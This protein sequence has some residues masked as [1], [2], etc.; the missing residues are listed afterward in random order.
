MEKIAVIANSRAG[1]GLE[2]TDANRLRQAVE[3]IGYVREIGYSNLSSGVDAAYKQFVEEA[4][5]KGVEIIAVNGGDGTIHR[6]VT[7]LIMTYGEKRLPCIAPLRGGTANALADDVGIRGKPEEILEKLAKLYKKNAL[8]FVTRTTLKLTRNDN[9]NTF[10]FDCDSG[11]GADEPEYGFVFAGG[12]AANFYR[13]YYRGRGGKLSKFYR[14]FADMILNPGK[15]HDSLDGKWAL[16]CD[17]NGGRV[18]E[19]YT[20]LLAGTIKTVGLNLPKLLRRTG[21]GQ[22]S[23]HLLASKE[24]A[25][26]MVR[27]VPRA[28]V[29]IKCLDEFV[30]KEVVL[31]AREPSSYVLDGELKKC[32]ELRLET[33]P[34]LL[35]PK[36]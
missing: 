31:K 16:E 24:N 30:L 2:K 34:K 9:Y 15:F 35:I 27:M 6:L 5:S 23:F 8:K 13:R 10:K 7:R 12:I 25:H 19:T 26:A 1:I 36:V 20:T 21:D 22:N 4:A 11:A 28:F 29:G 18:K 17:A 32:S 14:F 3:G 33:G